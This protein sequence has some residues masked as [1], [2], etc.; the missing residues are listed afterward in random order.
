MNQDKL[1]QAFEYTR[2]LRNALRA[3]LQG[4]ERGGPTPSVYDIQRA[5]DLIVKEGETQ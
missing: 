5:L 4:Y 3:E 2:D 1:N